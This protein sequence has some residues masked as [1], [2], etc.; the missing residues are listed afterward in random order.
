MTGV[1]QIDGVDV[2]VDRRTRIDGAPR[3]GD[4]AE[5]RGVIQADGSIRATRDCAISAPVTASRTTTSRL[6]PCVRS[7]PT[8]VSDAA[9][10]RTRRARGAHPS[11][12]TWS[13]RVPAR[14]RQRISEVPAGA[15]FVHQVS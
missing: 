6:A 4:A 5:V 7:K 12:A 11:A 9:G 3:V 10:S 1:W 14:A 13:H 8:R 2:L 15:R